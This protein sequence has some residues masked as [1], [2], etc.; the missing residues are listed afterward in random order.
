M[1]AKARIDTVLVARGLVSSRTRARAEITAGHVWCDGAP[2]G[3]PATHIK[4]DAHVEL[5]G[6]AFPWVSRAGVKLDHA[7]THFRFDLRQRVALDLGASTGGFTQVALAH[8]VSKVYA[9]DVGKAQFHET[10]RREPRVVL[11]EKVNARTLS[12]E[13][14]PEPVDLILCDVSFISLRKV[15]PPAFALASPGALLIALIK[16]Q[17]E[18]GPKA[19][20]K[21][22]VVRDPLVHQQVCHDIEHWLGA[23]PDWSVIGVI[24]SPILGSGGNKEFLIA[25]QK[26]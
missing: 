20:G 8:G 6:E 3:K 25:A 19:L 4:V 2:V 22:G 10:L 18:A 15:L 9:V 1:T 7:L 16:P 17:F 23:L 26:A 13:L 21:G 14:I 11:L 12:S 24:E 5:R